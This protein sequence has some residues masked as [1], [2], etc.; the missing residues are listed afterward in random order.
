MESR[1]KCQEIIEK[2]NGKPHGGSKEPLLVKFADGGNR[3]RHHNNHHHHHNNSH[4]K[5]NHENG[6]WRE[7]GDSIDHNISQPNYEHQ[8]SLPHVNHL[9]DMSIMGPMSYSGIQPTFPP[10]MAANVPYPSALG[11]PTSTAQWIHPGSGQA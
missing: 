3:K 9:N 4:H 7:S 6:R 2:L 10:A 8:R 11:P 1:D 5:L